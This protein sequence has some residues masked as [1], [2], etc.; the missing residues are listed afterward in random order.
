MSVIAGIIG[1]VCAD[2]GNILICN[3]TLE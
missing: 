2:S 1:T 3:C